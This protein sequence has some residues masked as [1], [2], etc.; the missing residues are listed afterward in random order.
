V[1]GSSGSESSGSDGDSE[2]TDSDEEAWYKTTQLNAEKSVDTGIESKLE[3][4]GEASEDLGEAGGISKTVDIGKFQQGSPANFNC[5]RRVDVRSPQRERTVNW[6]PEDEFWE[7]DEDENRRPISKSGEISPSSSLPD[8]EE[9]LRDVPTGITNTRKNFKRPRYTEFGLP[10]RDRQ[11]TEDPG[12]G[13][14]QVMRTNSDDSIEDKSSFGQGPST[15]PA[16][17]GFERPCSASTPKLS[18]RIGEERQRTE[19]MNERWDIVKRQLDEMDEE[20]GDLEKRLGN[21]RMELSGKKESGNEEVETEVKV[22]RSKRNV[23]ETNKQ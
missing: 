13:D 7:V 1:K 10:Q 6:R 14:K 16:K 18:V 8:L 11:I 20:L 17:A 12:E 4:P 22:R 9:V 2:D 19:Q 3:E 5:F 23:S 15:P 21:E